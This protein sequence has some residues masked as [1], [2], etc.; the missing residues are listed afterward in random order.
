MVTA[1]LSLG[2]LAVLALVGRPLLFSSFDPVLAEA[3]G[4]PVRLLGSLF[5]VLVAVTV[6]IAMQ[7]IGVLLVFALLVG[8]PATAIRL[9]HRPASAMRIVNHSG[10]GLHLAGNFAGRQQLLA[11][12]LLHHYAG[13]WCI[14]AG[15]LTVEVSERPANRLSRRPSSFYAPNFRGSC[16]SEKANQSQIHPYR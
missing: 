9:V 2:V 10:A 16:R 14:P 6:S 1:G 13:L 12:Q 4:L 11:G 15:T 3:R 8:P 5:L 7:V